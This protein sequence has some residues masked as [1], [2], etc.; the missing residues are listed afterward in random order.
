MNTK[1]PMK[2]IL[3]NLIFFFLLIAITFF[4][5][6]RDNNIGSLILVISSV[7]IS[8]VVTAVCSMFISISCE[9]M[10]IRRALK[11]FGYKIN[12]LQSLKYA[13]TGFFFSSITPSASGGQPMQLYFMYKDNIEVSHSALALLLETGSFQLVTISMAVIAFAVNY[14]LLITLNPGMFTL[15]VVGVIINLCILTFIVVAIFSKKISILLLDGIFALLFKLKIKKASSWKLGAYAQIEKYQAGAVY[16]KK[17]K[18]TVLK[19]ILTTTVQ[20][21][22]LYS[23]PFFVYKAFGLSAATYPV[24]LSMQAVLFISTSALPLPGAIG[25]SEGGFLT[26]FSTLFPAET[27]SAAM[28]LSRGI[29]FY[30]FLVIS[31]TFILL[32]QLLGKKVS[33]SNNLI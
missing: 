6:F 17:N 16:I 14:K 24:I 1:S 21:T 32:A 15:I 8:F 11:L 28:L 18:L 2:P 9:A 27:L 3:K 5:I 7:K 33:P 10:N 20:I 22:A 19:I 30:M 26:L 31:G 4:L 12:L 13:F 23:V 25:V 29:S